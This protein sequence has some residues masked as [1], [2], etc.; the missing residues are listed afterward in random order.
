MS[1]L[2]CL[3]DRQLIKPPLVCLRWVLEPNK[4]TMA[5]A[6]QRTSSSRTCGH[7]VG[8]GLYVLD[9]NIAKGFG[10]GLVRAEVRHIALESTST[11]LF[12][13]EMQ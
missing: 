4:S 13:S 9:S 7:P 12:D 8:L 2:L 10:S 5:L 11:D 6:G 1:Q 3:V